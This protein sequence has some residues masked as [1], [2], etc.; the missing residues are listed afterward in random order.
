MHGETVKLMWKNT[1]VPGRPQITIWRIR[2]A[3][4]IFKAKNTHSEYV[5]LIVFSLQ[6]WLH[7]SASVSS[8]ACIACLV[9]FY[10]SRNFWLSS[11][12]I[13]CL[14]SW[15]PISPVNMK[16]VWPLKAREYGRFSAPVL[17]VHCLKYIISDAH[18]F[19]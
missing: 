6:Q 7:E 8:Y 11:W 10:N 18:G 1:V 15:Y 3:C 13:W 19:S 16:T 2:I 14:K 9:Y 5:I 17:F 12:I 4:W